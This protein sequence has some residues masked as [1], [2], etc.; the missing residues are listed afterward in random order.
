MTSGRDL[1]HRRLLDLALETIAEGGPHA[2]GLR[3]L[4][5]RAEVSHAAPIHHFGSRRGLLTELA[6]EGFELLDG[7][8]GTAAPALV[9]L[10]VA[11]VEWGVGH[12]GHYRV[13][14]QAALL[15]LAE[16]RLKSARAST[17]S[18]LASH[19]DGPG[20]ALEV[21]AFALVHG[22]VQLELDGVGQLGLAA[23]RAALREV[24]GRLRSEG[25]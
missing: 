5:R 4:A 13:M 19:A 9:D 16:P 25:R 22:V 15:D 18:R 17:W 23:D 21:A 11:Y 2:I 14:W 12:P 10:G 20:R 3:D 1:L 24:L 7:A 6:A 8:L